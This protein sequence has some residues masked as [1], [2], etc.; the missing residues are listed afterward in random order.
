MKFIIN[1]K[2]IDPASIEQKIKIASETGW[3][4]VE[5]WIRD[6]DNCKYKPSQINRIMN[7]FGLECPTLEQINGWFEN[8]GGLMGV[9]NNHADILGECRR[10]L[11]IAKELSCRYLIACP[12]FSHRGFSASEQQGVEYFIELLNIGKEIGVMP[13]IEF[14]GQTGQINT[15]DSCLSFLN[16]VDEPDAKMVVDAYH[17]W[18]GSGTIDD[19]KKVKLEQISVLHIS[20]ADPDIS[21][22]NHWDRHRVIPTH[23]CIDLNRFVSICHSIGY[24][25]DICVGVYNPKYWSNYEES[26]LMAIEST[27]KLFGK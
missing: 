15:V 25:G 14:M 8:D 7:D 13:S 27:K 17:L 16:K 6:I 10:R 24:D 1:T 18:K 12:S 4:G 21:R 11:E 19:F 22:C 20:D 2:L 26:S 3:D 5:L 9:S 23:G